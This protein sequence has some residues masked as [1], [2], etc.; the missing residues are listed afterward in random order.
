MHIRRMAAC[1]IL[2][3]I[4]LLA[5]GRDASSAPLEFV[6]PD[7]PPYYQIENGRPAGLFYDIATRV[8]AEAGLVATFSEMP[9]KRIL[10]QMQHDESCALC[11]FGWFKTPEREAFAVFSLPV[12]QDP[13]LLAVFLSRKAPKG[14]TERS[15]SSLLADKAVTVGVVG[16]WSYGEKID[17]QLKQA[18]GQ[19][20]EVLDRHQQAH[21][22]AGGRFQCTLVREDELANLLELG[23]LGSEDVKAVQLQDSSTGSVRYIMCGRGVP[24]EVLERINAA[25]IRLRGEQ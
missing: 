22:L 18:R 7:R 25:I 8:L 15:L 11:S 4:T 12:H 5:N 13:P 21:M 23:G 10:L 9:S 2:A 19:V 6:Y 20:V 17:V 24:K 1:M 14:N 16:G 3:L